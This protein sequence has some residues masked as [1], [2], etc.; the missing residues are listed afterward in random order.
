MDPSPAPGEVLRASDRTGAGAP[1]QAR[2]PRTPARPFP[3]GAA[4]AAFPASRY[5]ASSRNEHIL[6]LRLPLPR[7]TVH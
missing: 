3:L 5:P 6:L 4:D 7:A 1:K 2:S